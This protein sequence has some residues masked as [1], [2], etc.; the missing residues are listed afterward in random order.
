M[1]QYNIT[2][3][4]VS[5]EIWQEILEENEKRNFSNGYATVD[6]NNNYIIVKEI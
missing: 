6:R 5:L 1:K 3:K 4:T 2:L